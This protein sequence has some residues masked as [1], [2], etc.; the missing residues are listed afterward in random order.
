[1]EMKEPKIPQGGAMMSW[2]SPPRRAIISG[3][4]Y[5]IVR[6]KKATQWCIAG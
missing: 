1:M 4:G 5:L 2:H 3:C 6:P